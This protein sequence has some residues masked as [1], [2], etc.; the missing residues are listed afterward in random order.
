M[1]ETLVDFERFDGVANGQKSTGEGSQSGADF[2]DRL[3]FGFRQGMGNDGGES[4][5]R[6]EILSQLTE[7]T[8]AAGSQDFTDLGRVQICNTTF[9]SLKQNANGAPFS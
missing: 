3:G 8:K 5:F 2:L 9:F 7:G 1:D 4:R 6:Q